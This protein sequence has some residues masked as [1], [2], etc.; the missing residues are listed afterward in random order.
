MKKRNK[1]P[2][3]LSEKAFNYVY[4]LKINGFIENFKIRS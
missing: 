4:E 3:V 2:N 1:S